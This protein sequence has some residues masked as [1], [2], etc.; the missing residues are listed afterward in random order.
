LLNEFAW[1]GYLMYRFDG[2]R[3]VFIDGRNNRYDNGVFDDYMQMTF[4]SPSLD[5]LLDAYQINTVLWT[6]GWPLDRALA[7]RQQTW[8]ELYRD[9][10]SV[11]YVR[12]SASA[13]PAQQVQ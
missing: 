9:A 13:E 7:E 11:I 8:T 12:R 10:I 5:A 3:P 4:A 6:A 1:G 2:A